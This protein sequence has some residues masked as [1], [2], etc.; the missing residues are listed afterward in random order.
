MTCVLDPNRAAC[1]L[2]RDERGHR[3]TPDIDNC[4]PNCVNIARTDRDITVLRDQADR[5]RYQVADPRAPPIRHARERHEL[6]RLDAITSGH[7]K[8]RASP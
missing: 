8:G 1:R 5:L 2:T 7:E 4:R 6:D 3:H